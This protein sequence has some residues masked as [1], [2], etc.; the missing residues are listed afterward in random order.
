MAS[1]RYCGS[2]SGDMACSSSTAT[3]PHH[4][5]RGDMSAWILR[6]LERMAAETDVRTCDVAHDLLDVGDDAL[7]ERLDE[8]REEVHGAGTQ[9]R[10]PAPQAARAAK[11]LQHTPTHSDQPPPLSPESTSHPGLERTDP[12]PPGM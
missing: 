1:Y 3:Q 12:L 6:W 10:V 2:S 8:P 5:S 4:H 11:G 7:L 9:R